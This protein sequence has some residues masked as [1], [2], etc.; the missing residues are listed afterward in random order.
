AFKVILRCR[1]LPYYGTVCDPPPCLALN[2]TWNKELK[3]DGHALVCS[4]RLLG[5]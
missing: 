1:P 2:A 3:I 5:V 4:A